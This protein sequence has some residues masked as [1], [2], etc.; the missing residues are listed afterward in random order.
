MQAFDPVSLEIMWSRM[1]N[2]AEEMWTTTLRTAV[3]TI[4]ASANPTGD[5]TNPLFARLRPQIEAIE[6]PP[7]YSLSWGGEYED[8]F[9]AQ[10]ALFAAI[11]QHRL[12]GGVGIADMLPGVDFDLLAG[13]MFKTS[14]TFDITTA[15]VQS[16]WI[17]AGMTWKFGRGA[18]EHGPWQ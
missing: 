17:G 1:L 4:I 6:L 8:S 18:V 10:S 14:Q 16:Y 15:T 13:G 7:G 5:L 9:E 12:T 3:S 2:I 11:P